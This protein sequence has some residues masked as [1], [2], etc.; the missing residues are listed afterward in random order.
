MLYIP[1][2]GKFINYDNEKAYLER[3]IRSSGSKGQRA[4][5]R[6]QLTEYDRARAS[7][8][9]PGKVSYPTHTSTG[10][11]PTAGSGGTP[12]SSSPPVGPSLPSFSGSSSIISLGILLG[13]IL[14]FKR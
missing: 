2:L 13:V 7:Q 1:S 6:N 11:Y 3:L 12:S 4:W 5:A 8:G 14:L 10:S 9:Y